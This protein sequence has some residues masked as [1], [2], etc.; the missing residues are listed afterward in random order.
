MSTT[1]E[2]ALNRA[3]VARHTQRRRDRVAAMSADVIRY[4]KREK[5]TDE[6][7]KIKGYYV[8]FDFPDDAYDRFEKL[9]KEHGRTAKQLM[10]E[11]VTIFFEEAQRLKDE[12]N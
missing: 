11:A 1:R 6:N 5:V 9:A 2:K 4:M 3:R 7:G 12:Q 10:H 8:T